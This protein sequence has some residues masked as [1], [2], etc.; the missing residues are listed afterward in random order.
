ML[1]YLTLSTIVQFIITFVEKDKL[2][3]TY[4]REVSQSIVPTPSYVLT[5]YIILYLYD[6]GTDQLLLS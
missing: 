1:S 3:E 5:S 4:P 2:I 6:R